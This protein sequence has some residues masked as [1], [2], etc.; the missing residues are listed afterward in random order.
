[1]NSNKMRE[2]CGQI[3]RFRQRFVQG[4]GGVLSELFTARCLG[5]WVLEE[6]GSWREW[7]YGPLEAVKISQ[8][9]LCGSFFRV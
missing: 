6:C 3:R 8:K 4:T 5:Q 2:V 7:V 1:M 9:T